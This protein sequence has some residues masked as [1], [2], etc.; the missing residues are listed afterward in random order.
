MLKAK[1]APDPF[2]ERSNLPRLPNLCDPRRF[3]ASGRAALG[4][5]VTKIIARPV[6]PMNIALP[7]QPIDAL[8]G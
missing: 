8:R 6:R 7:A 3:D 5:V 4:A 2:Q 1:P